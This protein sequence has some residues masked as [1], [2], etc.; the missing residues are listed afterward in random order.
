MK[1]ALKAQ[2]FCWSWILLSVFAS[3][4]YAQHPLDDLSKVEIECVVAAIRKDPQFDPELRFPILAV[5]EP[6][7]AQMLQ[8]K[9]KEFAIERQAQAVI[10]EPNKNR[11]FEVVVKVVTDSACTI[12]KVTQLKGMQPP[13]MVEEYDLVNQLVRKDPRWE[14]AMRKRGVTNLAEAYVDAWAPGLLSKQE[15]LTGHRYMR[16]LSYIKGPYKNYYGY[17]IEGVIATIDVNLKKVVEITD[18]HVMPINR[19]NEEF[20]YETVSKTSKNPPREKLK[21]LIS[22]TPDGPSYKKNGQQVSWQGWNFRYA[23]HPLKGLVIYD[24]SFEEKPGAARSIMYKGTLSEMVVPYGDPDSGW[25]FRNAFDVGEYGL[26]RTA[27][28]LERTLDVPSNAELFDAVLTDDLGKPMVLP[29]AVAIYERDGGVL[30]K[31]F[32][33]ETRRVEGRRARNLVITFTTAIGNYDYGVDWI[34]HQDGVIEVEAFLTGILLAKGAA[35]EKNPCQKECHRLS[36][37]LIV[38]PNHQHFFNFR[39]DMDV[40]GAGGNTPYE[41]NVAAHKKGPANP[42][43]NA[44]DVKLEAIKSEKNSG[45]SLN[46]PSART[47]KVVNREKFNM[48]GHPTGYAIEPGE[49]AVPYLDP[50]SD[51]RKRARFLDHTVWF[52]RYHDEEQ[53]AAGEYPNQSKGGEGIPKFLADGE[54]LDKEDVVMW[55]TFGVTHIPHPEQWPIMNAHRAGFKLV[56]VNFFARNPAMNVLPLTND[57]ID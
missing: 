12:A 51:I 57:D 10:F 16:G 5:K 45:R 47:W 19:S 46:I 43:A 13:I 8:Y 55:Y 31:H 34:F 40:D 36:A 37:P 41:I 32:D 1:R 17:P 44:F 29:R 21:P 56:P 6:A 3:T 11:L 25:V 28:T 49:T 2:R 52:T 48:L 26:G 39:L 18:T 42:A 14:S 30:W 35:I 33:V 22:K 23:F 50:K 15:R 53:S 24:V 9:I 7:K 38:T 4:T 27:H 20:D 54:S